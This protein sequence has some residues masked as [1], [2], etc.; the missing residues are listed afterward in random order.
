MSVNATT[1][2]YRKRNDSRRAAIARIY[3]TRIPV[4]YTT[5]QK[6]RATYANRSQAE[7]KCFRML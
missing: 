4:T 2:A 3:D 6:L 7:E 5:R 1:V